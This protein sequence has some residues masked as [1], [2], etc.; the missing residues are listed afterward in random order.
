V[1]AASSL[2]AVYAHRALFTRSQAADDAA[3]S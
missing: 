1:L 3:D 2:P